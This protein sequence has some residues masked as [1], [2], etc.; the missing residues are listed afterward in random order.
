[1]NP[2]DK[3]PETTTIWKGKSKKELREL[4]LSYYKKNIAGTTIV[5]KDLGIT[6]EFPVRSG[7]KTAYGEAMY[8]DKAE[9][10][11]ILPQ[12]ME[13]AVY[14]NWGNRKPQDPKEVIGYLNFKGKF[15]LDGT[16]KDLRIAVKFLKSAK[17]Y[18][19]LEINIIK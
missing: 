15:K 16:V 17:F 4:V 5:N 19:S 14:N 13:D 7:R 9:A 10:V 6:I 12:I 2:K 8:L 3:I 18:Y 1:M 11:R